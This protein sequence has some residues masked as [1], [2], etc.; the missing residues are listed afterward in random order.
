MFTDEGL[1]ALRDAMQNLVDGDIVPGVVTLLAQDDEVRIDA[2]GVADLAS[3]TPLREDHIFRIQSMTKPILAAAAMQLVERGDLHLD[4]PVERWL[5]ELADRQVLRT[6]PASWTTSFPRS[7][8]SPS[9][10][11]LPAAPATAW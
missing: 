1:A 7:G 4:N 8:R 6:R 9:M 3:G 5:P 2:C 11:C 10:T